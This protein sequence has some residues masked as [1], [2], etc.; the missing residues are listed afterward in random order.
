MQDPKASL[1]TSFEKVGK[2][3]VCAMTSLIENTVKMKEEKNIV[4]STNNHY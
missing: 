3:I 2:K 1:F 4:H